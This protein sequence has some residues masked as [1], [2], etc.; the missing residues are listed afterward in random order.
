[1]TK[2]YTLIDDEEWVLRKVG[3]VMLQKVGLV[4][5]QGGIRVKDSIEAFIRYTDKP[6][7]ANRDAVIEGLKQ[8]CRDGLIGIGRGISIHDLQK[9]WCKE[10]VIL[11]PNEEGL[12]IIPPFKPEPVIVD[13]TDITG[14]IQ[15]QPGVGPI[16]KS[17]E[18][19]TPPTATD[20]VNHMT[21][22]GDVFIEN[23]AEIFRCFIITGRNMNLKK[24]RLGI[25]FEMEIQDG[26]LLDESD[27]KIKAME[28]AARQLGLDF[29]KR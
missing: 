24:L 22:K 3:T 5:E 11:D 2:G 9:K 27:P 8:A 15:P 6:M 13:T 25:D 18:T 17:D 23:W 20:Q 19:V 16:D 12:W 7:I 1:L 14:T 21:I 26:V 10:D 4:P 28:E 29:K